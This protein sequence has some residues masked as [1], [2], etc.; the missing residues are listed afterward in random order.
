MGN[1]M[2]RVALK[3]YAQPPKASQFVVK[4]PQL[5]IYW[6]VWKMDEEGQAYCV[7]RL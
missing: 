4:H 1:T 6:V 7:E 2:I 3:I 5:N